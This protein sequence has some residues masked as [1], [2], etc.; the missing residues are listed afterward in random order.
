MPYYPKPDPPVDLTGLQAQIDA[1]GGHIYEQDIEPTNAKEGDIWVKHVADAPVVYDATSN[2]LLF[3][4]NSGQ[5]WNL[6]GPGTDWNQWPPLKRYY[7]IIQ[8]LNSPSNPTP[9]ASG[10][11][12]Y[13]KSNYGLWGFI[14]GDDGFASSSYQEPG[15]GATSA[16][17]VAAPG[18]TDSVQ[19]WDSGAAIDTQIDVQ[20][21]LDT[22]PTSPQ[23][24]YLNPGA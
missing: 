6:G 9:A 11:F 15:L 4:D 22:P 10:S 7:F 19:Q 17:A 12:V 14:L 8:V 1:L 3:R 5:L 13:I 20:F 24:M 16:R 18:W 21:T 2:L 23:I